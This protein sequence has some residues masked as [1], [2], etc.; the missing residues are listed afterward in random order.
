MQTF[1]FR[2]YGLNGRRQRLSFSSSYSIKPYGKNCYIS[3]LCMDVLHINEYVDVVITADTYFIAVDE[4]REQIMDGAFEN[5][6]VGDIFD[7]TD[8]REQ[9][10][11]VWSFSPDC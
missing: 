10:L 8:G 2:V 6:H 4:L 5:C 9:E 1:V 7:V 11:N 3:F